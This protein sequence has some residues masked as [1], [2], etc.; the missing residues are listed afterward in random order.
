MISARLTDRLIGLVSTL[1]LA[2][3]LT[4]ADFGLV[5]MAMAVIGL[6]ELASAFGFEVQLL[7]MAQPSRAQ[8]D[9]VWSLNAIFGLGCGTA[10]AI[11]ALPAATFYGDDRL[12]AIML[13]LGLGW[14]I[15]SLENVGIVD[16][17]RNLEFNKE[18]RFLIAKRITSF[19]VTIAAALLTRSYWALIAGTVAG[20][21]A[22]V[23]LSYL[24]HPYRPRPC[25]QAAREMF[26]FSFWIFIERMAA[27]ANSRSSDFYLGR[28][29]GPGEVGI[30]RLGEEIGYLP[31]SEFVAP[32]N[33]ALLPGIS[34]LADTGRQLGEVVTSATG[35]VGLVLVPACFG[36]A[37][38]ADSAVPVLLGEKWLG[39]IP[40]VQIMAANALF[41]ALWANQHSA[42][43]AIGAPRLTAYF[44]LVRLAVF[45][46]TFIFLA[47]VYG[48][49][50]V[51]VSALA[52]S[53]VA[54]LFGL[55]WSLNRLSMRL[56]KY[57]RELWRPLLASIVMVIAVR[58]VSAL[59][60][61]DDSLS[62]SLGRLAAG[63]GAGM[64]A[65][66]AGL[67]L[68]FY[69][70]GRPDG[71]ERLVLDRLRGSAQR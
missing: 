46:P 22:G 70:A 27:F 36:L 65:Y 9:T 67:L 47:P 20:R 66:V 2:R 30:Y 51:A 14:G 13:V 53:T 26:T 8:Y 42:L 3:L 54:Y 7:R 25:L 23:A 63:I 35:V 34:R 24:W 10:T 68:L 17:R 6:I 41:L 57:L 11:A 16:F 40:V 37:V 43:L 31:G 33:R 15:G 4:P 69:L 18:F 50:G 64:M 21:S 28:V 38:V 61:G 44:A 12:L 71:A 39:A 49:V 1:V 5:A 29:H 56:G 60:A 32:L 48:A 59:V 55:S 62:S 45:V 19:M 52:A 58:V